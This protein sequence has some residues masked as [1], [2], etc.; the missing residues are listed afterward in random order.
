MKAV[1]SFGALCALL[2]VVSLL[3]CPGT[4]SGDDGRGAAGDSGVITTDAGT[5]ISTG[6]GDG[7]ALPQQNAVCDAAAKTG[8][9]GATPKCGLAPTGGFACQADGVVTQ[10]YGACTVIPSG[11]NC[12]SGM[13]CLENEC[14][15]FCNTSNP[16]VAPDSCSLRVTWN[17]GP[18]TGAIFDSCVK[19][20]ITC[21]PFSQSCTDAAKGCY[22]TTNGTQ[23]L[24]PGAKTEG[25]E[26]SSANDCTR[27]G[28]C[29]S[30]SNLADGGYFCR[31]MCF[32]PPAN[33]GG[34]DGGSDAGLNY[35]DAGCT[36]GTCR[37]VTGTPIGFCG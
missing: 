24:T 9:S 6:V 32:V 16:C 23:C 33:D 17:G 13:Y 10:E 11:D 3:G 30:A 14:R 18:P 21:D 29:I 36:A 12:A 27:G 7:G 15:K 25:Q 34:T 19:G 1:S 28:T 35:P 4:K 22:V 26:C 37:L 31:Q 5:T 20:G 8:C 2:A